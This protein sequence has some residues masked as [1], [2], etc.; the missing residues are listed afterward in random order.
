MELTSKIQEI[1]SRLDLNIPNE[2]I[3]HA[4]GELRELKP[5]INILE[6]P[7]D[8]ETLV[9]LL[10]L[11]PDFSFKK[12]PLEASANEVFPFVLRYTLNHLNLDH[13]TLDLVRGIDG[14]GF[15]KLVR[16]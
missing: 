2:G 15:S 12:M 5:H 7:E 4:C 9:K 13:S 14:V 1:Q 3:N 8:L 10:D 6:K 16:S 11:R